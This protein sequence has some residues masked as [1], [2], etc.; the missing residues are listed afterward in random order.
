MENYGVSKLRF[1]TL[2][3]LVQTDTLLQGV[4]GISI[5]RFEVLLPIHRKVT[6]ARAI[7]SLAKNKDLFPRPEKLFEEIAS[8]LGSN[9]YG[10]TE[11]GSL[12]DSS[13]TSENPRLYVPEN[14]I[15]SDEIKINDDEFP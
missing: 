9:F 6:V 13:L 1:D 11:D 10:E 8:T 7:Y 2:G 3:L 14:K 12:Y 5:D 4:C 15:A